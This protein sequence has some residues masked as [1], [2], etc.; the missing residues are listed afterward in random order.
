MNARRISQRPY[1]LRACYEW[2][3]ACGMTPQIIVNAGAEG[4][5]VPAGY[6]RGSR[7][8]LNVSDEATNRLEI[9]NA[10]VT[11]D[12]RFSGKSF[13]LHIPVAA[14][15]GIYARESGE[16]IAFAEEEA[17]GPDTGGD[18]KSERPQLKVVK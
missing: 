9:S 17:T 8:V 15:L 14:V 10:A 5:L 12:A 3:V 7:I 16:G 1:F 11:F 13:H 6:A 4:V 2:I 18:K